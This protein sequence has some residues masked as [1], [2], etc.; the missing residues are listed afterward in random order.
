MAIRRATPLMSKPAAFALARTVGSSMCCALA[1]DHRV[2]ERVP[3]RQKASTGAGRVR[4]AL[5][6]SSAFS[7]LTLPLSTGR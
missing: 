5:E 2:T 4:S 3:V 7:S 1:R 6:K